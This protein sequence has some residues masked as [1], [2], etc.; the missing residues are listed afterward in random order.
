MSI[1]SWLFNK[2]PKTNLSV[3][4]GFN[5]DELQPV[6]P[7][8]IDS[9]FAAVR[10]ISGRI[11]TVPLHV[12]QRDGRG[13]KKAVWH[14]AYSLLRRTA[15]PS[16]YLSS[17]DLIRTAV[18]HYLLQGNA[19]AFIERDPQTYAPLF[20]TPIDPSRIEPFL[21][22]D[23]LYYKIDGGMSSEPIIMDASQ[24]LHFKG[25]GF[26]GIKGYSIIQY[27]NDTFKRA[28]NTNKYV[29]LFFLNSAIPPIVIEAP[30]GKGMTEEARDNFLKAWEKYHKGPNNFHKPAILGAGSKIQQLNISAKDAQLLESRQFNR[31]E[32]ANWFGVPVSLLN[33]DIA[34]SYASEEQKNRA[35][36]DD[37]L[38]PI[39]V[40][41][42]NECYQKL[43]MEKEKER[44]TH[45]VEFERSALIQADIATTHTVLATDIQNGIMSRNEARSVLN[46]N[47]YDGG[48]DFLTPL[49]MSKESKSYDGLEGSIPAMKAEDLETP[50]LHADENATPSTT[51]VELFIE[52]LVKRLAH[53]SEKKIPDYGKVALAFE[54][55]ANA[56]LGEN[57]S[58]RVS[59][60]ILQFSSLPTEER[61][62]LITDNSLTSYFIG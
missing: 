37:C 10:L 18:G 26:D 1:F 21:S 16:L 31:T 5:I 51:L 58:D 40:A 23:S 42:E 12:Y 35:F 4:G 60:F 28:A 32:I 59:S 27:A 57:G 49:N 14:P 44:D 15:N 3:V 50:T 48:D 8:S 55:E 24:I 29:S 47:P 61:E 17:T 41:I 53:E 39:L 30:S 38:N 43:L 54:K 2:T 33:G 62:T 46:L 52:R 11:S 25:L 13:K 45:L 22:E 9:V 36:L 6:N 20:L 56:L 19:Y 7:L 34:T